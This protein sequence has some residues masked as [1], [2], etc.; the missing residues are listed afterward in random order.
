LREVGS[1]WTPKQ[2]QRGEKLAAKARTRDSMSALAKLTHT[3]DGQPRIVD[4]SPLIVP[5]EAYVPPDEQRDV[6]AVLQQ[7]LRLYRDSL[8]YHRRKLLEQFTMTD[9]ARKVVGVGSVGTRAWIALLLGR[10]ETDP[11][12]LQVKEAEASVLEDS[13]GPS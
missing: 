7:L 11:L 2:A 6:L 13:L 9:F 8:D 1:E 4:Q 12:F 10:D 5:L 3:V